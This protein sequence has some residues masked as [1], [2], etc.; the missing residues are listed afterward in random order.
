M[1]FTATEL[2][3]IQGLNGTVIIGKYVNTGG[4]TGGTIYPTL[5]S[6]S[7]MTLQPMTSAVVSSFPVVNVT[8]TNMPIA[9]STGLTIVTTANE[10]GF[11]IAFGIA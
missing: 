7:G 5:Y 11:W 9:G 1:S 4:S 6:I 10:I 3:R 2:Q 8:N